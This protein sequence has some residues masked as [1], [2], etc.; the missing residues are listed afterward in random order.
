VNLIASKSPFKNLS[1]PT[2]FSDWWHSLSR[3][4]ENTRTGSKACATK[5]LVNQP[6]PDLWV[7]ISFKKGGLKTS[8]H[9]LMARFLS[10]N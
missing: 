4:C 6:V 8:C 1:L 5:T 7:I 3:L 9:H 10:G 2:S